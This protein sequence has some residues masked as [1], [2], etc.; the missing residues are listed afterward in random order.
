MASQVALVVKDPPANAGDIRDAC[1][2]PGSGRFPW[3]RKWLPTPVFLPGKPHGQRSLGGYSPGGHKELGIVE[4][5]NNK[6]LL[7]STGD[8][9]Q[10]LVI[11][12]NRNE[13]EKEERYTCITQSLCYVPT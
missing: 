13:S 8:Y 11:T 1:S 9:I 2:I 12:Y 7:Y 3:R 6:D 4:A 10:D 5:I